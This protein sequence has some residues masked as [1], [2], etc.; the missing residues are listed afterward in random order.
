MM[1]MGTKK[2]EKLPFVKLDK[3]YF[4][5]CNQRVQQRKLFS[6]QGLLLLLL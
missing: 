5:N 1:L 6:L 2:C 3:E 4:T